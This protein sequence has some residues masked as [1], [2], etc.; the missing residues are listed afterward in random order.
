MGRALILAGIALIV[1]GG[2]VM[3]GDK[4]PFRLGRIP[5]DISIKGKYGSFYFP[6]ATC[7]LAS[8]ILSLVMRWFGKR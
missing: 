1:L 8:V 5:G 7:L 4:L 6:L 3:L 2:M